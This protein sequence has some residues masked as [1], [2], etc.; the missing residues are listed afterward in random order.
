[1]TAYA[2]VAVAT[3]DAVVVRDTALNYWDWLDWL[4]RSVAAVKS[5]VA[6]GAPAPAASHPATAMLNLQ[7][8]FNGRA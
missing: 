1:M 8:L 2:S 5:A 3:P 4:D 7:T 6:D